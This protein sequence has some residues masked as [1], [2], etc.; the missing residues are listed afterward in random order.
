MPSA[1]V[2]RF[3]N[4]RRNGFEPSIIG[5]Q[6]NQMIR[7]SIFVLALLSLVALGG[8]ACSSVPLTSPTGST[9]TM[10]SDRS[11]LPL[12]GQATLRAVVIEESGTPVQNGTVVTFTSTLGTVDPVEVKTVNGVATATF[13]AGSVSGKT[14]IN[15][16][17]AAPRRRQP[18][19]SRLDR[20]RRSRSH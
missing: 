10:T 14:S 19:R 2:A 16:F 5:L 4:I 20:R 15:A 8:A 9:I 18:Q 13:N 6:Q 1:S 12:N 3:G 17:S 7:S 11:V